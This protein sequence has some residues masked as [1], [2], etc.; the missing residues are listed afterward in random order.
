[1]S[2]LGRNHR[3]H[4]ELLH[5]LVGLLEHLHVEELEEPLLPEGNPVR[6][7][8]VRVGVPTLIPDFIKNVDS[9][10]FDTDPD[11]SQ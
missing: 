6:L 11:P 5:E 1:M 7:K 4:P 2:S 9:V 8:V 10:H 3:G